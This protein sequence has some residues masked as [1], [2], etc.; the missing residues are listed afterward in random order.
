MAAKKK[1]AMLEDTPACDLEFMLIHNPVELL[2][3]VQELQKELKAM[4][5]FNEDCTK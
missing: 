5:L 1:K 4:R 2:R 3:G